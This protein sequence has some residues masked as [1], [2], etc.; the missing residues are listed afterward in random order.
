M[1]IVVKVG[2]NL[3]VG[4]SGLKKSYIAELCREIA[5]LK[6][7]GHEVAIIT[8]GA[9]AAGFTYLGKGKKTQDLH[10]KQALCAVG[11][12]QLMKVYENAFDFYDIKIAQILLTR[13]TFSDRKR[14]LNLRNTLIGLSEFDV[15]P[16]VNENDTVAT[17]EITLGDNDTLAAMFSIAWDAD[18]LVLFTTVD[19][20]IDKEGKLVERFD[21]SVELKDLGKSSWG[22]GGIRSKIEAALMASKCGVKV[23]ICNGNDLSNLTR[24]VRGESVGTVFEPRERLR[25]KKAWI[26]FLSEPSGKIY[27]NEGAEQALKSGGSLLPVGV[28]RVEGNFDVGDV[29]EILNEKG[30]LVG[31]G[32][33][34][35][36]SSD[37]ERI[38]GHRS[39]DLKKILGYEG[40]KVVVHIDNMWLA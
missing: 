35:Y 16:I 31:R 14:Y 29:V 12:V 36:S 30:E 21:E 27:V 13:D 23:T 26:A 32:I 10:T 40:S 22:T 24:F 9:R 39:S 7:Q 5:H 28:V 37:L 6:E 25:A 1:K 3:L 17:E 11:Q 2:S 18:I 4:S 34:N 19:G 38:S 33:V 20:V 15:V 8:S